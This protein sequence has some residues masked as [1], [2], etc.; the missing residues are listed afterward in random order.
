MSRARGTVARPA[1]EPRPHRVVGVV[2]SRRSSQSVDR[3][4]FCR[5]GHSDLSPYGCSLHVSPYGCIYQLLPYGYIMVVSPYG[6]TVRGGDDHG[7]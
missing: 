4:A 5:L 2:G 1:A 3:L 6:D 7:D